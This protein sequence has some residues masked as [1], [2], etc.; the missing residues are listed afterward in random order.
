[1]TELLDDMDDTGVMTRDAN[2]TMT[3]GWK[4]EAI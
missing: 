3:D 4:D 2:N 1:M